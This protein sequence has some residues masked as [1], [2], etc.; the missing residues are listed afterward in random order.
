MLSPVMPTLERVAVSILVTLAA[1][2]FLVVAV[3]RLIA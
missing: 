3:G 2:P 1:T